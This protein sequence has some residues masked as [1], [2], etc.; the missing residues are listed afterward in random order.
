MEY[1]GNMPRLDAENAAAKEMGYETAGALYR[2]VIEAWCSEVTAAPRSEIHG[3][4]KLRDASLRFL[5]SDWALTAL[6]AGWDDLGLFAVHEGTAPRERLD[7]WGVLPFF[8]WG[9]HKYSIVRF[10][11]DFCLLRTSGGSEL[12]QPRMRS[13]FDQALVWWAHPAIQ[14][15]KNA[16]A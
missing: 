16:R 5:A 14:G 9:V 1:D 6:A 7:A 12:R 4:D 13:N 11:R 2:A 3:F 10:E 8:T 15:D